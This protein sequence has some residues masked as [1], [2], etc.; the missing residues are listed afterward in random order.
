MHLPHAPLH[1]LGLPSALAL[2]PLGFGLGC[3]YF[4]ALRRSVD[5]LLS[6]RPGA[7]G[8]LL[9]RLAAVVLLLA[10]GAH[11]GAFALLA[12]FGGFLLARPLALRSARRAHPA[13]EAP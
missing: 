4:A 11:W 8:L 7:W 12:L 10:A 3:G 6:A 2:L 9:L 1:P 13:P 5:C